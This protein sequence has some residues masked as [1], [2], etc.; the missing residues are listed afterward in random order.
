M[1]VKHVIIAAAAVIIALIAAFY[2]VLRNERAQ[3]QEEKD[4]FANEQ[5]EIMQEELQKLASEYDIQYQKLSHGMGEQ[6]FS[7]ATDSL[8][9]QLLAE[10]AKVD[11]LQKELKSNKVT[12]AKRIGQLTQE[13]STLRNVLKNYVVQ[14]D[15]LQ[16]ANNRLRQ[17][18]T[19]VRA[20]YERATNEAQ[21]LSNEKAQLSDRVKLA[22]KLDA[23]RISIMP[24]D[25]R[26]KLSKKLEKTVNIQIH[27]T[28]AKNVTAAVG[29]KT[30]YCRITQP[31]EELLVKPGSGTFPFEGKHIPYSIRREIEYNGEDTA[32]TMYWPVEE[33]L[34]SGTY[35]VKLFADGN[36]IGQASFT[37]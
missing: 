33:S 7:L 35:R 25:K 37:L 23:T 1:K 32:V 2:F 26:G 12:S 18:N 22:A 3:L 8:I 10:R 29:E 9:S 28:V 16:S 17:E 15:S 11:Q 4:L 19:E 21:Q 13:V 24:I 31:N 34:Q 6:K 27:F 20:N 36:L 5:K 14:I 30:F